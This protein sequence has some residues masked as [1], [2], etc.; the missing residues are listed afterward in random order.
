VKVFNTLSGEKED[1]LPP[2]SEVKMYVCGVT[3]YADS[4]IGHAM[5]YI[6]FDA[7]RRYLK[8]RGYRVRYVQ[9]ITDI[10]D[11]IIDRSNQLGIS[12]R[13][14]ADKYT[15]S[16]FEDMAA[17]NI[18]PADVYP[19]AT[20][21][22][23]KIIEVIEGLVKRGYA[24][25]AAGSVYFRVRRVA[26]Y[27]NLSHRSL[28]KMASDECGVGGKDKEDPM[29]FALWKASMSGE[30]AWRSPWGDGRPGWHIECS[31][32]AI[33][34]LG[35]RIDIHGGGQDLIFP[36]HENEIAQ[37]ESFTG[38]KPFVKYWLHNGLL[39]LGEEKMSKSLGNLVTIKEVLGKHSPDAVRIFVL[40]SH[41][42]SPL[43]YS[44]ETLEAAERGAERLSQTANHAVV[45]AR[46]GRG[47]DIS[48]YRQEFIQAMDDD[49]NTAQAIAL[50]FDLA[51]EIN[52]NGS[53]GIEAEEARALLKELGSG[54][55]GLSFKT[56]PKP[57]DSELVVRVGASI[58]KELGL[59]GAAV[60][61]QAEGLISDLIKLR[62]EM[63]QGK[64]WRQADLIR[65]KLAEAGIILEDTSRGTVWRYRR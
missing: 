57:L 29:D 13:E 36:H 14:L 16:F 58:Y 5:S 65:N 39:K 49:F 59:A 64:K 32:M 45:G 31:A 23:P 20:E 33:T 47:I 42:R 18:E 63:R 6:I 54:V 38:K 37:S 3:P 10:D 15:R 2:G 51:R 60:G 19:K 40:S 46:A 1:F 62:S 11:K 34:Y 44:E 8:F 52:R 24:Y 26:D 17:L 61:G 35:E 50:L 43:T 28:E 27:G 30:P 41:Y 56:A 21:E 4:H 53:Q 48:G 12:A 55:L 22:I 9:N 25:P 7:I